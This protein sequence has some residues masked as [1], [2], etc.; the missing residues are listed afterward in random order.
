MKFLN[1][2]RSPR[3]RLALWF[4]YLLVAY[5]IL[6]FLIL[7][8][9]VRNVA[10]KQLSKQLGREVSIEKIEI[11]PF[12]FSTTV[13]GLLIK[14]KD[15]QPFVSWDEVYVNFEL[16]S[17]FA[18]T[19]TFKEISTSKPF[20]HV[21]INEDGTFN[22]SD[23]IAKFSTNA[24][25]AKPK[26][27]AK[28]LALCI[29]RLRIE[30]ARIDF[31]N[32]R[33]A[34][35]SAVENE[36][37]NVVVKS[38]EPETTA[39][40]LALLRSVTN[41]VAMLLDSA[42]QFSGTVESVD[43]TNGAVHFEDWEN[44]RPAKLDLS[45]ITLAAKN[46]SNLPVTNL[47]ADLSLHWNTDGS[48]KVA[49][50]VSLKPLSADVQLDLD[51]LDLGTL[52]PY[53]EPKLDL[54]ILSSEVG[55][56]GKI[57]L[58]AP[59]NQL[60]EITFGGDASL[61]N[62]RTVDGVMAEDLLK[63]DSLRVSGID[64]NL[65]PETVAIREI[66]VDNT[67]AR[68][69]IETNK[70]INLLNALRMTNA[71]ATNATKIVVA[72]NSSTTNPPLPQISIGSVVIS[73]AS[74]NFSDRSLQPNVNLVIEKAGGTISGISSAQLQHAD[75]DLR[76]VV[77]GIGPAAITGN[78]NPFSGTLTNKIKILV[79]DVDLAPTGPYS[80]KFAGYGI[81]EGKLNL[82]LTYELVGKKLDSTN[83]IMLDQFTFG[84]E[85][86]SPDATHLPV[87]LAVAILKDRDGKIVLDVP[88]QGSLDDPKFR[89][90]KVVQRAIVNIL[91]KVATSPFSLLGA[92]FGGGGEELGYQDFAAGSAELTA[93]DIKKLDILSKGLY[94]R[95]GLNL[96]IS[97]SVD[98]QGDREGLQR[99][100]LE[101]QIRTQIW[102]KLR[103][104]Q[105]ATNS[106]DQ[107]VTSPEERARWVKKFYSE[108][109]AD[110]K[111][112]P[113][114]LAANTNLADYAAQV[115]P[116]ELK[117][118]K[119]ATLLV[120]SSSSQKSKTTPVVY[121]TRLVPPP[122]PMEAVLLATF[123]VSEDDLETLAAARARAVQNY[124]LQHGNVQAP[125]LFLTAKEATFRS[126]G[127]RVYLQFR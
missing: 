30:G 111:I 82:D 29:E 88:I 65:N 17:L 103:K 52:D 79:K 66:A 8:P 38:V 117:E 50:T 28:P 100:M 12:A 71:P 11:N 35:N 84:E 3:R 61:D 33:A 90:G 124:L 78:I 7:P 110:K 67:Y 105:Q 87:R 25:P 74:I 15:G 41:T 22:F 54:F 56:H 55:L 9:I 80:A 16:S 44:S 81:A 77:D 126:D 120:N 104:S 4:I 115:L 64:V 91:E 43:V 96:E 94:E 95:P 5:A 83:V 109:L 31:E 119:G 107:I 46:I 62:F 2:I 14:E 19:W 47:T 53:L 99:A 106:V 45:D 93:D 57:S 112:T 26:T 70:T 123:P 118:E 48:I 108:A 37:T 121:Q 69:V 18:K 72:N 36:A 97:G 60:P 89:I 51:R 98:P 27:R 13:R 49:T 40:N 86:N 58:R 23:I 127:S 125:R 68:L 34:T 24:A 1:S 114:L 20:V 32:R 101:Q 85:V 21:Q 102:M 76:A 75:V 6:G 10:V 59:E 63:W 73:N 116:H 113:E 42:S 39:A 92:A 122:D